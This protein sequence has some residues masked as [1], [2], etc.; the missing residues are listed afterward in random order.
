MRLTGFLR[1]PVG[2]VLRLFSAATVAAAM[3]LTPYPATGIPLLAD[4]DAPVFNALWGIEKG[5]GTAPGEFDDPRG[6]AVGADGK[7]YVADTDNNRIQILSSDGTPQSPRTGF[8]KPRGIAVDSDGNLF[9]GDTDN[10]RVV[11]FNSSDTVIQTLTTGGADAGPFQYPSSVAVTTDGSTLYVAD[12]YNHCVQVFTWDSTQYV[13][14]TII[15]VYDTPGSGD[16]QFSNPQGVAVGPDGSVYV[17][18]TSNRRIQKFDADGAYLT[19]WGEY[20]GAS[21]QFWDPAGVSV[22]SEGNV[23]VADTGNGRIQESSAEGSFIMTFGTGGS[24]DYRFSYPDGVAVAGDGTILVADT[25]NHCIKLYRPASFYEDPPQFLTK[26]G[27]SGSC[28]DGD[29]CYPVSIATDGSG[30]VFVGNQNNH[31]VQ[32]FTGNGGFIST[33]GTY[34]AGDSQVDGPVGLAV[35]AQGVVYVA[36][37]GNHRVQALTWN[38]SE[39]RYESEVLSDDDDPLHYP[40]GVALDATGGILY[41]VDQGHSRVQKLNLS[42]ARWSTFAGTGTP[43]SAPE[44]LY[45]PRGIAVDHATGWVYV[46]DEYNNRIKKF[47]AAGTLL[48]QWGSNGNGAGQFNVPFGIALDADGNVYVADS[49]N[50]R[51]QKFDSNGGYLTQW[52]SAGS[53]AGEFS[54][55]YDVAVHPNGTIDVC[56]TGNNRIQVFGDVDTQ[57]V[58]LTLQ[59]GWN[60]VSVP[61]TLVPSNATADVLPDAEAV[62]WWDPDTKS[63]T[64]PQTID[65]KRAYWVAVTEDD[66]VTVTGT[67]VTEWTDTMTAGWNMVGSVY[68]DDIAVGSLVDVPDGAVQ[69][70]A[71]YHW[72]PGSKSYDVAS[73]IEQG[74]GYW[75]AATQDCDLTMTAPV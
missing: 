61:L 5:E 55:P 67:P 60:M 56:D 27:S 70:N 38:E 16:G 47:D 3:L 68:G 50:N 36:D 2:S 20:G 53:G 39:S 13:Y 22:D 21:G 35:D 9:V 17:A 57:Q 34:G 29:L 54:S 51:I 26:W 49:S 45:N 1:P 69:T 25:G 58:Q 15:G 75:V 64:V 71:I 65:P 40:F 66:T 24:G 23:W 30:N 7:V 73:V 19:Q 46:V 10:H 44:Q 72:N 63:Y 4:E 6:I 59:A 11:I 41:V 43:G 28:G 14:S 33:W 8:K 12:T 31:R 18:D 37:S 52:G 32:K 74:L 48:K 42:T 62:Y